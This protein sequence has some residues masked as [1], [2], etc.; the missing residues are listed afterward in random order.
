MGTRSVPV[1][2]PTGMTNSK[3]SLGLEA[4]VGDQGTTGNK[5]ELGGYWRQGLLG[6]G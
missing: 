1:K 3:Q 5:V 4:M 6:L 2:N